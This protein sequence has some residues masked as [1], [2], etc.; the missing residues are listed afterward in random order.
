M[1]HTQL[2]ERLKS[3]ALVEALPD[4]QAER[5]TVYVVW[6]QGQLM[7]LRVRL[8]VEHLVACATADP[9]LQDERLAL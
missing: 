6:T 3:G 4:W 5:R 8:L 1:P 7:P 2:H 9:L